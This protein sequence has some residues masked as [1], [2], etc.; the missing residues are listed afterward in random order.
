LPRTRSGG[1][2]GGCLSSPC[3]WESVNVTHEERI[4][5]GNRAQRLLD[6]DMLAEAFAKLEQEYIAQWRN[7]EFRDQ[8][9]RERLWWAARVVA[10]VREH[11]LIVAKNGEITEREMRS[12]HGG[13]RMIFL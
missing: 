3:S 5:R 1:W 9:A 11:L 4:A 6:D 2:G 12:L 13:K 7:T 8:D 10:K